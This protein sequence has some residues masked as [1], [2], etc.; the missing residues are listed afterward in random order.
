MKSRKV[1]NAPGAVARRR[2]DSR[3]A[4]RVTGNKA[5]LEQPAPSASPTAVGRTVTT[6]E[7]RPAVD[8]GNARFGLIQAHQRI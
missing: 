4:L 2:V 3:E 6:H 5:T 8:V 1:L 7:T